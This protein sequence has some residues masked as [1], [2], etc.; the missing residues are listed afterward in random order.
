MTLNL[1]PIKDPAETFGE[2]IERLQPYADYSSFLRN[3]YD[4]E[5]ALSLL[6]EMYSDRKEQQLAALRGILDAIQSEFDV[7]NLTIEYAGG[8]D[9]GSVE[10]MS[11]YS[12]GQK[13]DFPDNFDRL[14]DV[15]GWDIAYQTH[16]GFEINEGGS[17]ELVCEF[18]DGKW[19]IQLDHKDYI[20]TSNYYSTEF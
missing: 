4:H 18:V 2:Y 9:S 14:L 5:D 8:G 16:P 6:K 11:V 15:I 13:V 3:N 12:N 19:S 17:G 7:D 20:I 10:D 1:S